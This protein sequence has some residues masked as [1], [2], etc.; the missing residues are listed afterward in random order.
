MIYKLLLIFIIS[1][2][3]AHAFTNHFASYLK[4]HNPTLLTDEPSFGGKKHLFQRVKKTPVILIHGNSDMA[5]SSS[6][7]EASNKWGWNN[8]INYLLANGYKSSEVYAITYGDMN[9]ELGYMKYHSYNFLLRVR[10][11][12]QSVK[13]Y[14]GSDRVH[15]IAHSLGVTLSRKAIL[16]G[17]I[18]D[19]FKFGYYFDLGEKLDYVDTFIGIAGANYGL[20]GCRYSIHLPT[21]N[22]I[23]GFNPYSLF[24]DSLNSSQDRIAN[25]IVS[26]C[27]L[28]DDLIG[29]KLMVNG[30]N[31][32]VIPGSDKRIVEEKGHSHFE[33]KSL[34]AKLISTEL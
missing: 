18:Q 1:T 22:L 7:P 19:P 9:A 15:V 2:V 21:C 11:F 27:S 13:D 29:H 10:A 30:K 25:K 14:T 4:K 23:S 16:G 5:V 17:E 3:N 34:N 20:E 32:C 24:L 8:Q 33:V 12:I 6:F 31:T 28:N 26:I